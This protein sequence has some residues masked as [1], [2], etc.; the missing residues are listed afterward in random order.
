MDLQ[1]K[2]EDMGTDKLLG[3]TSIPLLDLKPDV[4]EE[5]TKNL[6]PSLDTNKVR[7]KKDRGSLTV[8]VST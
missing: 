7:D 4:E 1:V 6:S 5:V 3:E 8:K 2:D